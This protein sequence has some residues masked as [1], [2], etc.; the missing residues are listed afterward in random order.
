VVAT[1]QGAGLSDSEAA[2]RVKRL[3]DPEGIHAERIALEEL[4]LKNLAFY[5]G[6]QH[7][8][9]EGIRLREP[10]KK[11]HTVHYKANMIVGAVNRAASMIAGAHGT[12][13][14]VPASSSRKHRHQAKI[15]EKLFEHLREATAYELKKLYAY[16][17]A[18]NT[19]TYY[20]KTVWDPELGESD[21]FYLDESRQSALSF[22][23]PEEKIQRERQGLFEDL[24]RGDVRIDGVSAFQAYWDWDAREEG[25]AA[26]DWFAQQN[27]VSRPKLIDRFGERARTVSSGKERFSSHYLQEALAFMSTGL[28][29]LGTGQ[30]SRGNYED[31]IVRVVEY[32]ERPLRRNGMMGRYIV[33]VGDTVLRNEANPYRFSRDPGLHLPFVKVDWWTMPGRFTGLSMTEQLTA[34]QFQLNKARATQMELQ[35]CYGHPIL[36]VPK[37]SGIPTGMFALDPG[38]VQ[39]YN[40]MAG[41]PFPL[42]APNLPKEV[43]EN[44]ALSA[45]ELQSIAAN[46]DPESS[47]LPA[48]LRSGEALRYMLEEKSRVLSPTM[49]M[50]QWVDRA[51]GRN[52]LGLAQ[53]YYTDQR[54]LDYMGEDGDYVVEYFNGA[55]INNDLRVTSEPDLSFSTGAARA[56]MLDLIQ[57]GV[58]QLP[59]DVQVDVL[60]AFDFNTGAKEFVRR[61]LRGETGQ[62][63]EIHLV[64]SDPSRWVQTGYPV[65]DWEPHEDHARVLVDF[66]Q[67]VE[68]EQLDPIT[69]SILHQHWQAHTQKLEA[70]QRQQLEM[71]AQMKGTP[72]QRG[73]ASQPR[74]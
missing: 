22:L 60:R 64:I 20:L 67:T 41:V 63:R 8:A 49:T 36:L 45:R 57:S 68:F 65:M 69:K 54:K 52:L 10:I 38:L 71:M 21:R 50:S 29:G 62:E 40:A 1:I 58:M 15:S 27:F 53:H 7:F 18:A 72:G 6:K 55:D 24:P 73:V 48:Q 23:T 25:I 4:M 56:E 11:R 70:Q 51:V 42:P 28:G 34:P 9:Q 16:I 35:N 2:D 39:E 13:K 19:G 31:D 43:A 5:A 37:G 66:F 30:I 17:W 26:C 3:V 32:W 44:A 59:P 47:R 46:A 61:R 33:L 14:V 74:R 12:F